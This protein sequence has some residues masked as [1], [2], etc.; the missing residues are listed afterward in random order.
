VDHD[1]DDRSGKSTVLQVAGELVEGRLRNNDNS[2]Q[3]DLFEALGKNSLL[4]TKISLRRLNRTVSKQKLERGNYPD[5]PFQEKHYGLHQNGP[6]KRAAC[7]QIT[8]F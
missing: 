1:Q 8:W 7:L 2:A 3:L 4:R 6:P 5:P